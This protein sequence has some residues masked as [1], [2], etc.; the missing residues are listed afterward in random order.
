MPIGSGQVQCYEVAKFIQQQKAYVRRLRPPM[1]MLHTY[2]TEEGYVSRWLSG[3]QRAAASAPW[4][5][6]IPTPHHFILPF[7]PD[8]PQSLREGIPN[9]TVG[10]DL[11]V[12][13]ESGGQKKEEAPELRYFLVIPAHPAHGGLRR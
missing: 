7:D 2:R 8:K 5:V 9:L 1:F 10:S 4:S 11:V 13:P 3:E 6:L 12:S